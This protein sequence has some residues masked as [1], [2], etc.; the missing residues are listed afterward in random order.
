MQVENETATTT[1]TTTGTINNKSFRQ[2]TSFIN[3]CYC[4][5]TNELLRNLNFI[6]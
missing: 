4:F 5:A 2:T 6:I 1:T 3:I